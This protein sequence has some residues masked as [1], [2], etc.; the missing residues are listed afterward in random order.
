MTDEA[1]KTQSADTVQVAG[2]L[3]SL[4]VPEARVAPLNRLHLSGFNV[5]KV[6]DP[7]TIPVL[8]AT[9]VSAGGLLNPLVVVPE[10][11]PGGKGAQFGVVAGGRRLAALQYLA[12]RKAIR[13]NEPVACRVIS[14]DAAVDISL[15]ENVT[16]EVMHPADQ[17]EA[18]KK[19]QDEGKT[20]GQSQLQALALTDSHDEQR[21]AWSALPAYSRSAY[22]I[23]QMLTAE[24]IAGTSG[25]ARLVG[26]EAYRSAGGALRTDLFAEDGGVFFQDAVLLNKLAGEKLEAAAQALRDDGWRWA[27]GRMSFQYHERA[28]YSTLT[29]KRREPT[30]DEQASLDDVQAQRDGLRQILDGLERL[31]GYDEGT[32]E[33]GHWTPEQEEQHERLASQWEALDE[34]LEAM[35]DCLSEWSAEQKA[36]SGAVV[37]FN[38]NGDV[39]V[40]EGLV[41]AEDRARVAASGSGQ[42]SEAVAAPKKRPEYSAGLCQ[43]LTAHRT[44]AVAAALTESSKVAL[45]AL[46]MTIII[47]DAEPWQVSLLAVRFNS[48]VHGIAKAATEFDGSKAGLLLDRADARLGDFATEAGALFAQLMVMDLP[49]LVE[50]LAVFVGRAYGVVSGDA[51]PAGAHVTDLPKVIEDGLGLNM[52]DWWSP[53]AERFLAHVPKAKMVEAVTEACGAAVAHPIGKLKKDEAVAAA[54]TALESRGWLPS[55]LRPYP[56]FQPVPVEAS[57]AESDD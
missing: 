3:V 15:T 8:A 45:A 36:A 14:P 56:A 22:Q 50:L 42:V 40:T 27:E 19:L 39:L 13:V 47:A 46:L 10:K 24:E 18:F 29:A 35:T 4:D 26:V 57:D 2:R 20:I 41:R 6:R 37:Y 32:D 44:A 55:T 11:S 21:S 34:L 48:N 49:A 23:A 1:L 25:L 28:A 31:N 52:V 54:A 9:I 7:E 33:E 12:E 53:T 43:N 16:Q 5:R 30:A 17:L 51:T 38:G